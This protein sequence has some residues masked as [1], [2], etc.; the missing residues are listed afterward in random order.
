MV[1]KAKVQRSIEIKNDVLE[2]E[3]VC[4]QILQDVAS[5]G[6]NEE[7][8]FAIHLALEEVLVNALKHG[9]KN[10]SDKKINIEYNIT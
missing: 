1:L 7:E 2:L 4:R 8:V 6:F 10:S 9:N 3:R 5:D